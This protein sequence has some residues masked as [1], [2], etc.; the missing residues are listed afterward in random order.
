MRRSLADAI[1]KAYDDIAENI[2]PEAPDSM[3]TPLLVNFRL[4]DVR[5]LKRTI[6]NVDRLTKTA[7]S[8]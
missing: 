8:A 1:I 2:P 4:G 5:A 6:S 3:N 7:T